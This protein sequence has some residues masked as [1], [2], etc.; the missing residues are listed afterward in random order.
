MRLRKVNGKWIAVCAARTTKKTNDIYIDDEQD[1]AIRSKISFD[2]RSEG[3]RV[4]VLDENLDK[5]M[6]LEEGNL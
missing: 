3:L 4:P 1:H 6:T 2:N 5:L